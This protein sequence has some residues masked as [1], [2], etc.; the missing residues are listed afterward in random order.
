M[1]KMTGYRKGG[2]GS[3]SGAASKIQRAWANKKRKKVGLVQRTLERNYQQ[4]RKLKKAPERKYIENVTSSQHLSGDVDSTGVNSAGLVQRL[5]LCSGIARGNDVNQRNGNE[6]TMK[7]MT[8]HVLFQPPTGVLAES[9]NRCTAIL[10]H[11]KEPLGSGGLPTVQELYKNEV[12]NTLNTAFLNPIT[13]GGAGQSEKRYKILQ[14][15][16][17]WVGSHPNCMPEGYM[18]LSS[19]SPY[20]I[21]YGD[22]GTA[23]AFGLN[24][25]L[26]LFL[27]SDSTA[28]PH[29]RFKINARFSYTDQ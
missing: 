20:K 25:T 5:N 24:Q 1:P 10:V 7:R 23:A 27:Y 6:V 2:Y 15:K 21:N 26:R 29:P 12:Y 28:A 16:T 22:E 3:R 17:I 13:V 8:I 4:I 9:A 19:S 18:T 14:R 11:D